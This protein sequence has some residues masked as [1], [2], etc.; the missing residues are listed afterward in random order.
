MASANFGKF[1]FNLAKGDIDFDTAAFKCL[2]VTSAPSE[3]NLDGWNDRADVTIEHPATGGY[4]AGGFDVTAGAVTEDTANNRVSITFTAASPTLSSV[5]LAGVVGAILYKSTGVAADDLLL[6]FI[7]YG[8][9]KGVTAGNF[10][11]T[12]TT[13]LYINR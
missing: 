12:F 8:S 10:T 4:T 7:D 6:S 2:L 13:P 1:A 5:T 11:H 3:A 9:T